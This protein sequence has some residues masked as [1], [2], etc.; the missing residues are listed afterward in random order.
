[1]QRNFWI[2]FGLNLFSGAYL[3]FIIFIFQSQE[4]E[5]AMRDFNHYGLS[6]F[7][8]SILGVSVFVELVA[9]GVM[10]ALMAILFQ[11]T[12]QVIIDRCLES[13]IKVRK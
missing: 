5:A 11:M 1:M 10:G 7:F 12:S 6:I 4:F 8:T 2:T 3:F 9:L 13:D